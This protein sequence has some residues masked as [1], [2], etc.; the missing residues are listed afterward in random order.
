[1]TT[2]TAEEALKSKK[3]F[4]EFMSQTHPAIVIS[5]LAGYSKAETQVTI[6]TCDLTQKIETLASALNEINL[7]N[8]EQ[9]PFIVWYVTSEKEELVSVAKALNKFSTRGI[10]IFIFKAF[11]ND[12]K[13]EFE[14]IL[15]PS[16]RTNLRNNF[17]LAKLL[18]KEYWETYIELC[19]LSEHPDMQIK[20]ALPQHY[21]YISIQKNGV[22]ILQTVNTRQNYVASEIAINNNKALF[23]KLF[24][25]KAEI[26]E[27]LGTLEWVSKESNKSAKIR[28][29]FEIDISKNENHSKAVQEQIKMGADLK[30]VVHKYL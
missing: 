16:Q 12:D 5:T 4:E 28:K 9:A 29:V 26:E 13:M 24:E 11:L 20:E 23:D 2:I 10:K 17:T 30:A 19:D 21:Q 8:L 22:Q 6:F 25:H 14:C 27:K 15:K 7:L 3:N 18:Q 1:M